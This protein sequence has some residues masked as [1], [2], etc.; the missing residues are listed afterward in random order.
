MMGPGIPNA[1][2]KPVNSMPRATRRTA[3]PPARVSSGTRR[4]PPRSRR[5]HAATT[6]TELNQEGYDIGTVQEPVGHRDIRTSDRSSRQEPRG[7]GREESDGSGVAGPPIARRG[8]KRTRLK[9]SRVSRV[10]GSQK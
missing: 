2:R 8:W 7:T 10:T 6:D 3:Q 1:H 5:T 4:W 9:P